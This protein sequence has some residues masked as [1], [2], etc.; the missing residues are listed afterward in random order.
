MG[1]A[2]VRV[3]RRISLYA[4]VAEA[5]VLGGTRDAEQSACGGVA[6]ITTELLLS[7]AARAAVSGWACTSVTGRAARLFPR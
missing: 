6:D 5:H 4:T 2:R 3:C 1:G 7:V